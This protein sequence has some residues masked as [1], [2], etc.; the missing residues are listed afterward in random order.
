MKQENNIEIWVD[1]QG[2]DGE[3][4]VS[5]H[6]R[7]KSFK[8]KNCRYIKFG[9]NIHGY[10]FLYLYKKGVGQRFSVHRLVASHFI[11]N[12]RGFDVVNHKDGNRINNHYLN[13][14]W[15]NMRENCCH[16]EMTKNKVISKYI[17][18]YYAKDRKKWVA[19]IRYN[20]K[21]PQLG[22]YDTEEEAHQAYLRFIDEHGLEN[23]YAA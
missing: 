7:V 15:V 3:Y 6:G 8:S 18:V 21:R 20:G 13:L 23:K 11:D 14:E 1:I 19:R 16:G 12:N 17:G 22:R 2:Y 9:K 5:N 10:Y 4:Q